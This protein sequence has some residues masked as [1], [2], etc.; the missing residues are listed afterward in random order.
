MRLLTASLALPHVGVGQKYVGLETA[1]DHLQTGDT[2][3]VL[4]LSRLARSLKHLVQTV[5]LLANRGIGLQSVE[6][7]IDTTQDEQHDFFK[8]FETLGVFH[9]NVV[10]ER[11]MVGLAASRARGRNGGRPK[12][13][14]Q[15]KQ[16]RLYQLYDSKQYLIQEICQMMKVSKT[17]LYTYLNARSEA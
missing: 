14:D 13:L 6:D 9:K 3:V 4:R 11:T 12:A 1:L 16:E 5:T 17:T 15:E 8:L 2:L 10:R 7:G